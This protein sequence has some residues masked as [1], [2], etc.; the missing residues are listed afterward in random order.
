M[1]RKILKIPARHLAAILLGNPATRTY[2]MEGVPASAVFLGTSYDPWSDSYLI[3]VF[4]ESF[5]EVP[6][7]NQFPEIQVT[8]TELPR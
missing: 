3:Q 6:D 2:R 4:D 1:K 7:G 8:I 5:P